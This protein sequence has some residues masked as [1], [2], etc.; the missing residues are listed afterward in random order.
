MP[1]GRRANFEIDC[2]VVR[3]AVVCAEIGAADGQPV[4][5]GHEGHEVLVED[6]GL[7]AEQYE[8]DAEHRFV[9][10]ANGAVEVGEAGIG[11]ADCAYGHHHRRRRRD[12]RRRCHREDASIVLVRRSL[13]VYLQ[14]LDAHPGIETQVQRRQ[15]YGRRRAYGQSQVDRE[16]PARLDVDP[17]GHAHDVRRRLVRYG[18]MTIRP[19]QA[20]CAFGGGVEREQPDHQHACGDEHGANGGLRPPP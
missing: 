12:R 14:G 13:A 4:H 9:G 8:G 17:P 11:Y 5:P 6:R 3:R 2:P 19:V 18:G 16:P 1:V 7:V 10:G 15:R 20:L